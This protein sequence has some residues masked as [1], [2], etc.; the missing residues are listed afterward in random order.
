[1]KSILTCILILFAHGAFGQLSCDWLMEAPV[2]YLGTGKVQIGYS[3]AEKAALGAVS[4]IDSAW[5]WWDDDYGFW[6]YE[7]VFDYGTHRMDSGQHIAPAPQIACL[8][9]DSVGLSQP[10][11]FFLTQG[12]ELRGKLRLLLVEVRGTHQGWPG[13]EKRLV[14]LGKKGE[15]LGNCRV[16]HFFAVGFGQPRPGT[17]IP[18]FLEANGQ[19]WHDGHVLQQLPGGT[20]ALWSVGPK[21]FETADR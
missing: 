11:A 15:V 1:M 21:G 19:I 8:A 20:L 18:Q 2:E 14:L 9:M 13:S 16:A 5:V 6:E 3:D 17:Q 12:W 10:Q 7:A 4:R